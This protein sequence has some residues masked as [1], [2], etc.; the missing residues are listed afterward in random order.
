MRMAH[1]PTFP[2]WQRAV[3]VGNTIRD[4]DKDREGMMQAPYAAEYRR[5]YHEHWWWRSREAIL[6]DLLLDLFPGRDDLDVLDVGC[7]D[8]LFFP[9]LERFGRV[10]GIELD[11]G[12]LDP[13]GPYRSLISTCPL[14]DP[15]YRGD[16]WE[17]DLVTALDVIEHIEDDRAAVSEMVR[18][19]RPGGVLVI[20]VPA[21]Q[22]LWAHH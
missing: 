18:M 5:L 11:L 19:L 20:T 21:F 22:A 4:A 13:D 14:G 17:F 7:G 10:R 2:P 9:Q 8:G 12:L 15:A 6:L 1:R 3:A 16:G